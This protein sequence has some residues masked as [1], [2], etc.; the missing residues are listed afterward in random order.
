MLSRAGLARDEPGISAPRAGTAPQGPRAAPPP[1]A[2]PRHGQWHRARAR[3]RAMA[4]VLPPW[5]FPLRGE[6]LSRA[7]QSLAEPAAGSPSR[8]DIHDLCLAVPK[9]LFPAYPGTAGA[10]AV[11]AARC[12][13]QITDTRFPWQGPQPPPER[14]AL[15]AEA[16]TVRSGLTA[17][18]TGSRETPQGANEPVNIVM[19]ATRQPAIFLRTWVFWCSTARKCHCSLVIQRPSPSF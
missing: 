14:P 19:G 11:L 12:S 16:R 8:L 7:L 18:V 3:A 17:A 4:S 13:S 2:R 9:H 1:R 6:E 15:P 5:L 10:T